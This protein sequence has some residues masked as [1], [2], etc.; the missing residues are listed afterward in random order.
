MP[1]KD[2]DDMIPFYN[3]LKEKLGED[4][5]AHHRFDDMHHGFSAAR[6]NMEDELNRQRV[7][8]ALALLVEFFRKHI[9]A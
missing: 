5:C 3:I 4:K 6:A 2:E 8:E 7:D 9:Q 1:T